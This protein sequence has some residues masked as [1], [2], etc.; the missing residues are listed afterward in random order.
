[1]KLTG[2]ACANSF[3]VD[4]S[5]VTFKLSKLDPL[6]WELKIAFALQYGSCLDVTWEWAKTN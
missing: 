5:V 4:S 6:F 3:S 2:W 1:M